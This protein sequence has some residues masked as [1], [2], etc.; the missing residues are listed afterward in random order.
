M[1]R[2]RR[3]QDLYNSLCSSKAEFAYN[4]FV[5]SLT[6]TVIHTYSNLKTMVTFEL[7]KFYQLE[8][9]GWVGG[10]EKG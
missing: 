8:I 3:V 4:D 6:I 7:Y 9:Y 5:I 2:L 1:Y 10:W